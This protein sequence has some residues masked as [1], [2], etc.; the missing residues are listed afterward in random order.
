VFIQRRGF[1][2]WLNAQFFDQATTAGVILGQGS[3]PPTTQGQQT[4]EL[5]VGLFLPGF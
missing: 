1:R 3:A 2:T 4:H 5:L